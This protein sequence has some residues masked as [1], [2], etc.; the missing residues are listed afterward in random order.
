MRIS[1]KTIGAA[2]KAATLMSTEMVGYKEKK[3]KMYRF[4]KLLDLSNFGLP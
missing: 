3:G 4:V 1:A 2:W